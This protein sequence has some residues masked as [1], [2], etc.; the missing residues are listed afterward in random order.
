[1]LRR[2]GRPPVGQI[3]YLTDAPVRLGDDDDGFAHRDYARALVHAVHHSEAPFTIGLFGPW[4]LGKSTVLNEVEVQLADTAYVVSFDAWRYEDEAFRRQFLKETAR[5]LSQLGALKRGYKVDDEM[6]DLYESTATPVETTSFSPGYSLKAIVGL[7]LLAA[8]LYLAGTYSPGDLLARRTKTDPA[9]VAVVA[10]MPLVFYMLNRVTDVIQ[11]R[12]QTVTTQRLEDP[13]L[14]TERFEDLLDAVKDRRVVVFIDN[15]D[16][17]PPEDAIRVL[18]TIK[19]YL[20]PVIAE[21]AKGVAN[22]GVVFVVAADDAALRKHLA[23]RASTE[24]GASAQSQDAQFF[25]D[26]F[27][28]KFFNASISLRP[29]LTEDVRVYATRYLRPLW[30]RRFSPDTPESD[31][32]LKDL[33]HVT[34]TGLRSNPRRI[35]QFVNNLELRLQLIAARSSH[36]SDATR[37]ALTGMGAVSMVAK[38]AVIEEEWPESYGKIRDAPSLL[39][40]WTAAAIRDEEPSSAPAGEVK[41]LFAFLRTTNHVDVGPLRPFLRLKGTDAERLVD[42][43]DEFYEGLTAKDGLQAIRAFF[44][45]L[46]PESDRAAAYR[47]LLPDILNEQLQAGDSDQAFAVVRASISVKALAYPSEPVTEVLM[48]VARDSGL[49]GTLVALDAHDLVLLAREGPLWAAT[50]IYEALAVGFK[51]L[52]GGPTMA[53][54]RAVALAEALSA[55]VADIGASARQ[56]LSEAINHPNHD[57]ESYVALVEAAPELLDAQQAANTVDYVAHQLHDGKP[58]LSENGAAWMVLRVAVNRHGERVADQLFQHLEAVVKSDLGPVEARRH[59]G[60]IADILSVTSEIP[61]ESAGGLANTLAQ[62]AGNVGLVDDVAP[63]VMSFYAVLDDTRRSS[64]SH[65]LA[66]QLGR[67]IDLMERFEAHAGPIPADLADHLVQPILNQLQ[68]DPARASALMERTLGPRLE[69]AVATRAVSASERGETAVVLA[70]TECFGGAVATRQA[71]VLGPALTRVEKQP[72]PF[73]ARDIAVIEALA[74]YLY[75]DDGHAAAERLRAALTARSELAE[76][77]TETQAAIAALTRPDAT[78]E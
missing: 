2:K 32:G 20:E 19:T 24:T 30:S 68:A 71:D 48:T 13:E 62:V 12:N 42:R 39:G 46:S 11:V 59:L 43:F 55:V 69:S 40:F 33:V 56:T 26:E 38:L 21:K 1:M 22:L 65:F 10:L 5:Q 17:L 57:F 77:N 23:H 74:P 75:R 67:D 36:F 18:G 41:A 25:A 51:S 6:K 35:K 27:L 72:V 44:E 31:A 9:V 73:L 50:S 8:V 28:R 49:R 47:K 14:F 52:M 70:L 66:A 54:P 58:A 53:G 61:Q 76:L 64:L 15:V 37:Q 16:R 3:A 45:G 34:A 4:G 78:R 60:D 7:A 63:V 29:I